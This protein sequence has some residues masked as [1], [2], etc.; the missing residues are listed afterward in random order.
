MPN[1]PTPEAMA[2]GTKR[3]L[4]GMRTAPPGTLFTYAEIG[5]IAASILP[6]RIADRGA[7]SY[8]WSLPYVKELVKRGQLV[9]APDGRFEVALPALVPVPS[10][11]TNGQTTDT[12]RP[13]ISKATYEA[14]ERLMTAKR[15]SSFSRLVAELV[16]NETDRIMS[17]L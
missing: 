11:R 16:I 12:V 2:R 4:A 3:V 15:I 14:A 5:V 10:Q 13:V 9:E 1:E 6:H 7:Y 8:W 17:V